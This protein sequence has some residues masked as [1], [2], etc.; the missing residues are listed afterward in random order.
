M[1]LDDRPDVATAIARMLYNHD[2][3]A[4]TDP[5]RAVER[6]TRG[7]P[8]DMVLV[9]LN[10]PVMDGREVSDALAQVPLA[11]PP[12]ILM[13]SGGENVDSMFATG[14]AVLV[15][16]FNGVEL[17]ALVA[18]ILHEDAAPGTEND[19]ESGIENDAGSNAGPGHHAPA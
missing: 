14:R 8:F 10:M 6:L 17:R 12:I 13:M 9:D 2:A 11:R 7:E 1:V 4:E 18:A 19:I 3:A 5:Q 15:K 16:P